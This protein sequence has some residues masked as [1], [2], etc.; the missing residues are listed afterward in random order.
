MKKVEKLR[1]KKITLR[2]HDITVNAKSGYFSLKSQ[3]GRFS[4]LNFLLRGKKFIGRGNA[5]HLDY[6]KT[7]Y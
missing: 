5:E 6:K 3:E 4:Q 1:E 7:D 2:S